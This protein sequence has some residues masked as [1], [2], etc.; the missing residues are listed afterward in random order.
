MSIDTGS[1]CVTCPRELIY[2]IPRE[3]DDTT[4]KAKIDAGIYKCII[5]AKE[6]AEAK[7]KA[8]EER[9][10]AR[11]QK[12]DNIKRLEET[13][14]QQFQRAWDDRDENGNRLNT[15]NDKGIPI[16]D[17]VD[18]ERLIWV[19]KT[20]DVITPSQGWLAYEEAKVMRAEQIQRIILYAQKKEQ[21]IN[22]E[23]HNS[24]MTRQVGEEE[25]KKNEE[26]KKTQ[27]KKQVSYVNRQHSIANK[28]QEEI[29]NPQD[30]ETFVKK[31]GYRDPEGNPAARYFL[32]SDGITYEQRR[33]LRERAKAIIDHRDRIEKE[34]S[35]KNQRHFD[36]KTGALTST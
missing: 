30:R 10:V 2:S 16:V 20:G 32:L 3:D 19:Y 35:E 31:P 12:Q 26:N 21:D 4:T 14:T 8:R 1:K 23:M 22:N 5:C 18:D 24:E 9:K 17:L 27:L 6:A 28:K 36:E 33:A 29:P 13:K 25:L 11:K 15:T 34:I 7:K